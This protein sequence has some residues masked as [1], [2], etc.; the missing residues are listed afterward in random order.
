M[1]KESTSHDP[2]ERAKSF[3]PEEIRALLAGTMTEFRELM[4]PQPVDDGNGGGLP[5]KNPAEWDPEGGN[6]YWIPSH[7]KLPYQ[8]GSQIW[9]RETWYCDHAFWGQQQCIGCVQCR[10]TPESRIEEWRQELYYRADVP[11]GRFCDAGYWA[12]PGSRWRSSASM[13]RWA[14]RITLEVTGVR[15]QRLQEMSEEDATNQGVISCLIPPDENG[16][17]R[18]G[19]SM[20]A[21]DGKSLLEQTKIE[22]FKVYWDSRYAK[23]PEFQWAANPWVFVYEFRRMKK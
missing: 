15:V 20:W 2:T 8:I 17:K 14:S 10:C 7:I 19:Y 12:E 21:D 16:P 18:V 4:K 22:A 13:P 5:W 9:V 11:S 1:S 3:G 23:Q 6:D